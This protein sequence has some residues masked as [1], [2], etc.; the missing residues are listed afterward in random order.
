M[1][2]KVKY[3]IGYYGYMSPT[4]KEA[5]RKCRHDYVCV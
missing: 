3:G 5:L 2:V 1:P 4:G